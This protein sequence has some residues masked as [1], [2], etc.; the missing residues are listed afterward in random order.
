MRWMK[1]GPMKLARGWWLVVVCGNRSELMAER[2]VMD[3][4][5]LLLYHYLFLPWFLLRPARGV[6]GESA[7]S[8][9]I[10]SQ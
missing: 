7:A 5:R 4:E 9:A 10:R 1:G 8:F 2:T 6:G 3:M